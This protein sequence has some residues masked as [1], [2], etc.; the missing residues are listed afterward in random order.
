TSRSPPMGDTP[1]FQ[2]VHRRLV[3]DSAAGALPLQSLQP[4]HPRVATLSS[5]GHGRRDSHYRGSPRT[6]GGA[7]SPHHPR[8]TL[9]IQEPT[10]SD[11]PLENAASPTARGGACLSPADPVGSAA[12]RR[13]G[14]GPPPERPPRIPTYRLH[15]A[16][17]R[18]AV[19]LGGRDYYTL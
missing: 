4:R 17:G 5:R 12:A 19:T 7:S 2:T 14:G 16:S 1:G 3:A 6:P 9:W 18:A 8:Y 13:G 15:E 11:H 10:V